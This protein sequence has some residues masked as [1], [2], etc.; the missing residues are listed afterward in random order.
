MLS[1]D[2]VSQRE[3]VHDYKWKHFFKLFHVQSVWLLRPSPKPVNN[4]ASKV[5]M[6]SIL[7]YVLLRIAIERVQSLHA[8]LLV[9]ESSLY[10]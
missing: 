3:A 8:E 9:C 10:T 7:A 5:K 4:Q 2:I 6:Y 1:I